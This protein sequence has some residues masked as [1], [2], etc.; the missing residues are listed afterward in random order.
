MKHLQ[1]VSGV[2][3]LTYWNASFVW[4]M[5]MFVFSAALCDTQCLVK[6]TNIAISNLKEALLYQYQP[7]LVNNLLSHPVFSSR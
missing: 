5:A 3:P 7:T 2:R 6:R 4:D 1:F